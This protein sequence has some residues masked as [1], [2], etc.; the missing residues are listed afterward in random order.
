[1]QAPEDLGV[2]LDSRDDGRRYRV[3]VGGRRK[4]RPLSVARKK[5]GLDQHAGAFEAPQRPEVLELLAAVA[6]AQRVKEPA[7]K[8]PGQDRVPGVVGVDGLVRGLGVILLAGAPAKIGK[9]FRR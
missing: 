5:G 8:R 1:M 6:V 3:A 2:V 7:V 4:A 9:T